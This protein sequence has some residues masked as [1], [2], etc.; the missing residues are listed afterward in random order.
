MRLTTAHTSQ[1]IAGRALVLAAATVG[2]AWLGGAPAPEPMLPEPGIS[3]QS[4][5][6][7]DAAIEDSLPEVS[8]ESQNPAMTEPLGRSDPSLILRNVET[9]DGEGRIVC[10]KQGRNAFGVCAFPPVPSNSEM[11]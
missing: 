2:C 3:E 7:L 4:D 8:Y 1:R 9:L 11:E 5:A 6:E 10:R